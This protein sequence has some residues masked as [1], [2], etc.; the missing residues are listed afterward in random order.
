MF[1]A[2]GGGVLVSRSLGEC[3][4]PVISKDIGYQAR[5]GTY[6]DDLLLQ[7]PILQVDLES[8]D[9]VLH[10]WENFFTAV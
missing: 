4:K 1:C 8:T 9:P 7:S 2:G 10:R 3:G 5:K 6:N